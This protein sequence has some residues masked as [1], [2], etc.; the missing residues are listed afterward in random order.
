MLRC[1][2]CVFTNTLGELESLLRLKEAPEDPPS[3]PHRALHTL[4]VTELSQSILPFKPSPHIANAARFGSYADSDSAPLRPRP[5]PPTNGAYTKADLD[6][7]FFLSLTSTPAYLSSLSIASSSRLGFV[8]SR[9][10]YGQ[11]TQ[12][13][14]T[15]WPADLP[16]PSL[17]HHLSVFS[18]ILYKC[19]ANSSVTELR[20]SLLSILMLD[21]SST[22]QVS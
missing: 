8:H 14:R 21:A 15:K 13:T 7:S 18:S 6:N 20:F 5:T 10:E 12:V 19:A 1:R 4:N 9:I 16:T 3:L 11:S 2:S 22:D 17:M